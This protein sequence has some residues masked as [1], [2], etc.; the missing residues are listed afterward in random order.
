MVLDDGDDKEIRMLNRVVKWESDKLIYA[1]DKHV[2]NIL[3]ELGFDE[4]TKGL[5]MPTAKD[6]DAEGGEDDEELDAHEARRY[7]RT[8]ATINYLASDRP[9]LQFTAS[10]LGR[11]MARPASWSNLKKAARYLKEHSRVKYEYHDVTMDEVKELVG[12]SDSDWAGCKRSRRSMSGGMTVVGGAVIKLWSNRQATVALSSGEAEFYSAGKAA[13]EL[14]GI[15][16]MMRD[17]GWDAKGLARFG[18]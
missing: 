2:T 9:D 10:M 4:N 3:F 1:D 14:I 16:S 18:I 13:A 12:Y 8:A 7:R 6:H 17:M 15:K 5:D 11:T